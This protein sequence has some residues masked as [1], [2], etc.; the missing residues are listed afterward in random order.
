MMNNNIT[1][2]FAGAY[3]VTGY[4]VIYKTKYDQQLN[5]WYVKLIFWR[6]RT[7]KFKLRV[8][9]NDSLNKLLPGNEKILFT[10]VSRR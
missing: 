6:Q 5:L 7:I 10:N 4:I 2:E 9:I 3:S 8:N 1:L